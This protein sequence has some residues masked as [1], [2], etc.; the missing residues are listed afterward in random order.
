[1]SG[2][3]FDKYAHQYREIH[4]ANIGL[5][6]EAPEYFAAYKMRD[7][8]EAIR[9]SGSSGKGVYLDFGSGI[10]SSVSPFR[11]FFPDARLLCAD[12]SSE[13]L[14]ES[15][16]RNGLNCEYLLI[17]NGRLP[18]GDSS[19]DGAFACCVFHHIPHDIHISVLNEIR[20][21][22]RPNGHL[23]IYEH[24]PWNPLTVRAVN[25]CPLDENAILIPGQ[26]MFRRC[27]ASGF[28]SGNLEYRV[29]FPA[30]LSWL[31]PLENRLRWLSLG[32]QYALHL[33]A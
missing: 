14:L 12:V 33:K 24:N 18:L 20:R 29:F 27:L 5:S 31:R 25:T 16:A 23:M 8:A 1:M 4:Q 2:A 32:A 6:G 28:R 13:S 21:V 26:E 30:S 11:R 7:F 3:E 15:R 9:R 22:L 19:I 17:E 10:G